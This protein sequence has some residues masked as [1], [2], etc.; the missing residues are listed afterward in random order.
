MELKDKEELEKLNNIIKEA[1]EY[2]QVNCI[3]SDEW[4]EIGFCRFIP[5]GKIKFKKLTPREVKELLEIL[6]KGSE[7]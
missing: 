3:L 4:T 7:K 5:T 2:I 1:I 6:D